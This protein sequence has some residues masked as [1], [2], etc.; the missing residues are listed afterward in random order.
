[1][2]DTDRNNGIEAIS[3]DE[4]DAVAGGAGFKKCD[5]GHYEAFFPKKDCKGCP[6][7][8][9]FKQYDSSLTI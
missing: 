7:L 3:D 2:S 1:M 4:L 9:C 8:R 5:R 6:D